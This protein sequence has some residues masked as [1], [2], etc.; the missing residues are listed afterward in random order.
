LGLLTAL[1]PGLLLSA[2]AMLA[3]ALSRL[4]VLL[5]RLLSTAALLVAVAALLITLMLLARFLFVLVHDCSV[6]LPQLTNANH[7][8]RFQ[9]VV[10][11]AI[12]AS[13][14]AA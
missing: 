8:I 4:L 13:R 7:R 5:A 9:A 6:V 12:V 11:A 10:G 3:A 14:V 2:T 1:L